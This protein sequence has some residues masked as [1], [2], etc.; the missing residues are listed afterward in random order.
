MKN[1]IAHFLCLSRENK[2]KLIVLLPLILIAYIIR[3]FTKGGRWKGVLAITIGVVG[4]FSYSKAIYLARQVPNPKLTNAQDAEEFINN[5]G[6]RMAN[7]FIVAEDKRVDGF[8]DVTPKNIKRLETVLDNFKIKDEE[9][10]REY[11]NQLATGDY[12]NAVNIHNYFWWQL[13]G[14]VGYAVDLKEEYK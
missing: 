13:E 1:L 3:W 10:I 9:I 8:T 2:I 14:D 7:N 4:I 6:H 12:S 11:L 5:Y